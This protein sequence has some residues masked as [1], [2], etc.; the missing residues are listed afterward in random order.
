MTY[1]C[2]Q[3]CVCGQFNMV[4]FVKENDNEG[5]LTVIYLRKYFHAPDQSKEKESSG[6]LPQM[7]HRHCAAEYCLPFRL[8]R[9]RI[10]AA[11]WRT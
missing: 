4:E 5:T 1:Q 10:L 3:V 8:Q 11:G 9:D 2:L 7:T 6:Q